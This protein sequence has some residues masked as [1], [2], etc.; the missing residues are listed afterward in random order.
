MI[1]P[2][3]AQERLARQKTLLPRVEAGEQPEAAEAL[4]PAESGA[5][6]ERIFQRRKFRKE[7]R[8]RSPKPLPKTD[9]SKRVFFS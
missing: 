3:M 1:G 8:S 7:R 5:R 9:F 6:E 2:G 4:E